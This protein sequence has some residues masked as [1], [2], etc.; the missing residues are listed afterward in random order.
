[1]GIKHK[2]GRK[3][4]KKERGVFQDKIKV[5]ALGIKG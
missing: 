4:G 5:R 2:K 3:E 1:M